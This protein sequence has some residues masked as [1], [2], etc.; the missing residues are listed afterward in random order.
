MIKQLSKI[1]GSRSLSKNQ[2]KNVNG[3]L[4]LYVDQCSPAMN[5][6]LCH[7]EGGYDGTCLGF[8]CSPNCIH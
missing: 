4:R 1:E 6:A 2:Q 5:G 3:G 8:T 7:A